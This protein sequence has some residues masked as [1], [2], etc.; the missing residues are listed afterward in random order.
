M[1]GKEEIKEKLVRRL[2]LKMLALAMDIN[3]IMGYS[4]L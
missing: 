2:G 3:A 1:K 4:L